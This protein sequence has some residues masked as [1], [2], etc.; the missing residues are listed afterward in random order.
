MRLLERDD[1]VLIVID[2]QPGF[3]PPGPVIA[4]IA[5]LAGVA[6]ALGVPVVVTE[7]DPGRN[8]PTAPAV[9]ARL[10]TG[11]THPKPV[12]GLAGDPEILAAV[13]GLGR[14]TVV[15]AGL[16]TD[17]CVSQSALGL[18]DRG[19]R[20]AVVTDAT[21]SPAEMHEAGL[22]RMRDAGATLIHAKGVYYEWVRTLEAARAFEAAHPDLA[23][24]PGFSL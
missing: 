12:F 21:A 14:R 19:Y 15:L 17:V 10:P 1:C 3:D 6:A 18:L 24:P 16:E 4:R 9:I 22:R 2:V 11:T 20:V 7:E 8:G 5:W 13:D 23:A